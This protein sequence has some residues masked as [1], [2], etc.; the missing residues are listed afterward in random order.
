[1]SLRSSPSGTSCKVCGIEWDTQTR[2]EQIQELATNGMEDRIM[3]ATQAGETV[4]ATRRTQSDSANVSASGPS[5]LEPRQTTA[6]HQADQ[7]ADTGAT[8][9]TGL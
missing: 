1:M 7:P 4:W 8:Q 2:F 5:N 9:A 6:T 3:T